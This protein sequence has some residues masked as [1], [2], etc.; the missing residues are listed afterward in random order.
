MWIVKFPQRLSTAICY[1]NFHSNGKSIK[2]TLC[3]VF[4]WS[5]STEFEEVEELRGDPFADVF[6]HGAFLFTVELWG[7]EG[8]VIWMERAVIDWAVNESGTELSWY[9]ESVTGR[10]V[11]VKVVKLNTLRFT[12]SQNFWVQLHG[13]DCFRLV[14]WVQFFFWSLDRKKFY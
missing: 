2:T 6:L 5:E 1:L 12:T 10:G 9:F 3:G 14:G 4:L 8:C 7:G 11:G 13:W